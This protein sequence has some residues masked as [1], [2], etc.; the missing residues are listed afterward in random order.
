MARDKGDGVLQHERATR[1][2][3]RSTRRVMMAG[4]GSSPK[5]AVGGD[6]GG[7]PTANGG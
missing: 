6:V 1:N 5:G 3:G 2:E 4:G 7:A